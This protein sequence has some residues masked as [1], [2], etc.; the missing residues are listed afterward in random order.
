KP[1]HYLV[2]S[3]QLYLKSA[4]EARFDDQRQ[5]DLRDAQ[6]V[7]AQALTSGSQE[8]NPAA[9]YYLGH[10]YILT[11][12]AEGA[13]SAFTKAEALK[14][15]CKDDIASWRRVVWVPTFNAGVAAWQA[16]NTDSAIKSFR[17]AN[18]MLPNE[19][20]GFKYMATLF[21]NAGQ[22]DSA[23]LYFRKAADIA[24][25]NPKFAQDR[26]D[27]LFNL[28]RIQQSLGKLPDAQATYR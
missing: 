10:Y 25:T 26:K 11:N 14:P 28:G 18:S 17:R 19:P 20:T 4:S 23:V 22:S 5:K 27:V 12:D 1:G 8:K 7:L 9:W 15:D 13:D 2:N 16:N 24:A 3:G 21:Y 6:R